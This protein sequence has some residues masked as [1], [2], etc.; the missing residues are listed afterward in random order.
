[1]E[2]GGENL[3]QPVHEV[4]EVGEED[5]LGAVLGEVD[6]SCSRVSLDPGVGGV[7]HQ[8]QQS[9]DHLGVELLLEHCSP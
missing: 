2:L 3:L 4:G 8:H 6:Q 7:L 5:V 9:R 1:M